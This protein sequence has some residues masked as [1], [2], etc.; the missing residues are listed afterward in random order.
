MF[1]LSLGVCFSFIAVT[2]GAGSIAAWTQAQAVN[3]GLTAVV[4]EINPGPSVVGGEGGGKLADNQA[5]VNPSPAVPQ[6]ALVTPS[7]S[8]EPDPAI[9]IEKKIITLPD[10]RKAP[11]VVYPDGYPQF[12]GKTNIPGA[13]IFLQIHSSQVIYATTVADDSGRWQWTSPTPITAGFHTINITAQNPGDSRI[14]ISSS[15]DFF[16]QPQANQAVVSPSPNLLQPALGNRGNL[17]DVFVTI[18]TRFKQFAP[19][20]ELIAQVKLVNF[21]SPGHPVDV[22]VRYTI[23][24]S[25]HRVIMESQDTVAVATQISLIKTFYTQAT[26]AEGMYTLIVRVPTQ[27]AIALA[28]DTFELKGRPVVAL[29]ETAKVDFTL[30]F[31]ALIALFFLFVLISYFEYNK[32]ASLSLV[33][34][35]A[36]EQ[37]LKRL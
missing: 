4:T 28:S 16:V 36:S 32:A 25:G 34:K 27:D 23:E 22:P 24:N 37:D 13:L 33:M 3:L 5:L 11:V 15:M 35:R 18:A 6:P 26:L 31:Q 17:F 20:E 14:Q 29:S 2:V 30:I 8:I 1:H 9:T 10:G 12:S 19:G 7:V 21:G